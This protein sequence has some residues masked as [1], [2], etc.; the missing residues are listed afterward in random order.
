MIEQWLAGQLQIFLGE[1]DCLDHFQSVPGPGHVTK[2]SLV[3]LVDDLYW[4]QRQCNSA[5]SSYSL[6]GF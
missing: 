2:L 4:R 1:A 6:I 3:V 5:D